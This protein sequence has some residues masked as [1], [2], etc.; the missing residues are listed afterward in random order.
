M[1]ESTMKAMSLLAIV[2]TSAVEP[3]SFEEWKTQCPWIRMKE[4]GPWE[5]IFPHPLFWLEGMECAVCGAFYHWTHLSLI[6]SRQPIPHSISVVIWPG[7]SHWRLLM[8]WVG[9]P[10]HF[11][12]CLSVREEWKRRSIYRRSL[13]FTQLHMFGWSGWSLVFV[14]ASY[15]LR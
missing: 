13:T 15:D 8:P 12:W 11:H 2:T 4:K 1:Q 14:G 7:D 10:C 6:S 3:V 5:A 9:R